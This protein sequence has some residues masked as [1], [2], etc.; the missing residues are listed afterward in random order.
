[1]NVIVIIVV[2]II[3][4]VAV[5][6]VIT[7]VVVGLNITGSSRFRVE[8]FGLTIFVVVALVSLAIICCTSNNRTICIS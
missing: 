4:I 8:S 7:I 1:M 2:V 6:I 5:V 3:V